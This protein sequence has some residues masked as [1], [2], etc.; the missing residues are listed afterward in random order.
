MPAPFTRALVWSVERPVPAAVLFALI[1]L[2]FALQ[3]PRLE[4]DASN[5]GLML[6]RDPARQHYEQVKA[7]FGSDELTVVVVKADDVFAPRVLE[8]I[9]RLSDALERVDGVTRVD[10]LATVDD[11]SASEDALDVAPLLRGGVPADPGELTRI[12][13]R[14]LGNP[15]FAGNLVAPDARAAGILLFTQAAPDDRGFNGRFSARVDEILAREAAPGLTLYQIGGPLIKATVADFV[16]RD[17]MTLIPLSAGTLFLVLLLGFRTAQGVVAPIVTGLASVIW[18]V[19]LM[20]LFGVPINVVTVAVPSLVLVVGFAEAVH[21]I[22]SYH[23][24]LREGH[25]KMH[26]LTTAVEEA[27]LPI[28]V[29]TATTVFAFATLILT[30][31]TML[32]QFGYAATLALTANFAATLLGMPLLLRLWPEPR[33]LRRQ[34]VEDGPAAG[35]VSPRIARIYDVILRRRVPIASIFALLAAASVW[36][37]Y[38][39]RVDTDFTSYFPEDSFVRQRLRDADASLAGASAFFVVVDTGRENGVTEPSVLRQI[40][41]LQAFIERIPG[42]DKTVSIVDYISQLHSS[43]A[44]RTA[45]A[46]EVPDSSDTVAQHLLIMERRQTER[47]LDLPAAAA[48]V[49]VRHNLNGSWELSDALRRIETYSATAMR[50]L[51][52]RSAGQAVLT[53]RAADYMAVNEVTSFVY[54]LA[55]IGVIHSALFLSVKAG[56]LSLIPNVVPVVYVFGVMGLLGIPLSTGTAM[57]ATIAIGIAVDDTV[58][59]MVAYNRQL[60]IHR[61]ERTAVLHTMAIQSRPIVFISLALAAGFGILAFSRFVPTVHLAL[62]SAFVMIAAMVSELVLSPIL[63]ASTRL[64][65]LWD[66]V[67]LRMNPDLVRKAPLLEGLSRWEAR[68]VILMGMLRAVPAGDHVVRRGEQ[69]RELYMVVTGRIVVSEC[70]P[71]GSE[72]TLALVAPGGVFGETGVVGDAYRTFSARADGRSEV[73]RLDFEAFERLRRRFPYTAAK[74]FRN[75]A[76]ILSERLQDTTTAMLYLSS[77]AGEVKK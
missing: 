41:D 73:L 39:L 70:E 15:I 38:N 35:V 66:M 31:I 44:G 61:D 27:A 34:L 24:L 23:R 3:L 1:T 46:R 42:V 60:T 28:L 20:A 16:R 7:T 6:E 75:L 37:W 64:V 29:T 43:F 54:T 45:G 33:R 19:G 56:L 9:Q 21:I 65:T 10:S 51:D 12:R 11:V 13:Q 69:G 22:A 59:N 48:N 4:I 76:R 63:M 25:G 18:G 72:R 14:A 53:S 50:G 17:Q 57:V 8:A 58:H 26:A 74:V 71:D 67:L 62:L 2:G 68:K 32:K 30:D 47:F 77:T 40:S 52:V 49:I 36:G 5:E 55:I